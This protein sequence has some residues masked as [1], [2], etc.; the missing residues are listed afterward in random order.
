MTRLTSQ[1]A[2]WKKLQNLIL[3]QDEI[4]TKSK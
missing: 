1:E 3:K 2:N 4:E